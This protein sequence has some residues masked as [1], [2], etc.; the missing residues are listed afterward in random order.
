MANVYSYGSG[1]DV[2]PNW[3]R[4]TARRVD[5]V[6]D[7]PSPVD[8]ELPTVSVVL[9]GPFGRTV[10]RPPYGTIE[11][12]YRITGSFQPIGAPGTYGYRATRI[13]V[14]IGTDIKGDNIGSQF[15][16]HLRH[17]RKGTLYATGLRHGEVDLQGGPLTPI[18][19]MGPGT[20]LYGFHG[21]TGTQYDMYQ[22]VEGYTSH[23]GVI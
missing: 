18:T 16:W 13:S 11:G 17:S 21:Q 4:I 12:S 9:N 1:G 19:A 10:S 8:E 5:P 2:G 23:G 6:L 20:L 7:P 15:G 3:V 22:V 14:H